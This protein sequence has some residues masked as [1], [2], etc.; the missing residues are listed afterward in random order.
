MANDTVSL[1]I[2][3]DNEARDGLLSEHGFALWIEVDGITVLFD[4]GDKNGL[5][6]NSSR[7]GLDLEQVD[8]LVLSH[9]HYDHTGGL[10]DLLRHNNHLRIY[11]HAGAFLPRYSINEGIAKPVKMTA[12]TMTSISSLPE[13]R[14]F[15]VVKDL[16]LTENLGISGEI[17]R[18]SVFETT[19][20]PFYF[21]QDGKKADAIVDDMALWITTAKGLIICV[22]CCHAGIINT[23]NH[24]KKI[25]G[26]DRIHTIVGGLHLVNA[27]EN[28]LEETVKELQKINISQII[29]CH[30]TGEQAHQLLAR[31]L[32]YRK[33]FAGLELTI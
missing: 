27:D 30:C 5:L 21:D 3:V 1:K 9:G 8:Y 26:E 13:E 25:S 33:G 18:E 12:E 20:G 17:P 22:G 4:T 11:C 31:E 32:Y 16:K 7:M 15:W 24:I 6:S 14:L 23:I 29:P 10:P 19:G 2:V 28:R